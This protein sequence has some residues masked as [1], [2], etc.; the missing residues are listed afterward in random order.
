M[1]KGVQANGNI[2]EDDLDD[3]VS[4]TL[5]APVAHTLNL[6]FFSSRKPK[7]NRI[8]SIENGWQK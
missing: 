8:R 4:Y 1:T 6:L 5:L 2:D 7:K 3:V